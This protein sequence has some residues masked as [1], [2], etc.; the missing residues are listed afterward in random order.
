MK[1]HLSIKTGFRKHFLECINIR[2]VTLNIFS[3]STQSDGTLVVARAMVL[4][5]CALFVHKLRQ[6]PNASHWLRSREGWNHRAVAIHLKRWATAVGE[7][8]RIVELRE[9]DMIQQLQKKGGGGGKDQFIVLPEEPVLPDSPAEQRSGDG[10]SGRFQTVSFG[11]KMCACVLLYEITHYLRDNAYNSFSILKTPSV[12]VT[13]LDDRR[14]SVVSSISTDTDAVAT[15]SPGATGVLHHSLDARSLGALRQPLQQDN[16][17]SSLEESVIHNVTHADSVEEEMPEKRVSVYLRVN[18]AT[19][20]AEAGTRGRVNSALKPTVNIKSSAADPNKLAPKRRSSISAASVGRRHVSFYDKSRDDR[21]VVTKGRTSAIT[22]GNLR[23][24]PGKHNLR[25]SHSFQENPDAGSPSESLTKP[26]LQMQG[27]TVSQ[28][29]H[30]I[31]TQIQNGITRLARRAFR[32]KQRKTTVGR[33]KTSVSGSSPNL[34][35]KKRP[36]RLSQGLVAM[37]DNK[38]FFPWL[39]IVE[40][41]VV[42]DALNPDAHTSHAQTCTELVTALNH[43]YALQDAGEEG[44][45]REGGC[46]LNAMFSGALDP[47]LR[48]DR[49]KFGLQQSRSN[50]SRRAAKMRS[51]HSAS[52]VLS[53]SAISNVSSSVSSNQSFASLDFSQIRRSIF[54]S[55]S[56]SQSSA[57]ELFL[58]QDT[59]LPTAQTDTTYN[60]ARKS[61]LQ[62]SFAGLV[63][64]PFSLLVYTAPILVSSTFASLKNVAWETILDR[65]QQLAEAAGNYRM[66]NTSLCMS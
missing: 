7:K 36:R 60:R 10:G 30:N 15:P 62:Q 59:A 11:I 14:S 46:N 4:L 56:S 21:P 45:R 16:R 8:L 19:E 2:Y 57:I 6:S 5:E 20:A 22:V 58:E 43:V 52:A 41:L 29:S 17:S 3:R 65:D 48:R 28:R 1:P 12:N 40:H 27:S 66:Q 49:S 18:S 13:N 23:P 34:P 35:Q 54:S 32:V 9:R 61:Y 50:Q 42:V 24:L 38:R 64:A 47:L 53:P 33:Q 51:S 25:S 63:H 31:G 39:D 26:T 44:K 55:P 37:E